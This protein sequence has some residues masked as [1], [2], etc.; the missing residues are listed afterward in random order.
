M[1]RTITALAFGLAASAAF[2]Q[3]KQAAK[4]AP[5]PFDP[6]PYIPA[7]TRSSYTQLVDSLISPLDK[8]RISTGIL[9]DRVL[10]TAGLVGFSQYSTSSASHLLQSYFE[11]YHAAYQLTGF[12]IKRAALSEAAEQEAT[13]ANTPGG[14]LPI[15]V[16]DYQ[17]NT[18]DTLAE[19]RGTIRNVNDLYYDGVGSPYLSNQV[20]LASPLADSV[21]QTVQVSLPTRFLLQ[22][23][24]RTLSS[25]LMQVGWNQI[26]LVPGSTTALTFPG[27]GLQSITFTLYFSDGS[28]T[29][30]RASVFVKSPM[31]ATRTNVVELPWPNTVKSLNWRGYDG[32]S[33]YGEGQVKS[34]LYHPLSQSDQNL[35]NPIM[36]MDGFDP[37]DRRSIEQIQED[38]KQLAP[39][40]Q[41][42]SK[43]RDLVILNFPRT[44][45]LTERLGRTRL[46]TIDGG[47]D[48]LER[49]ALVV[50]QL[51]NDMKSRMAD[52]TQK[53][54]I[55]APS[56]GGLITRYAL[57]LMEKNYADANNQATYLKP[58][59]KHN[60]DLYVSFD[61]PHQG[62]VIPLGD[63]AFIDYFKGVSLS[64]ERNLARLNSVAAR[65]MLLQHQLDPSGQQFH[66]P[67]MRAV[68]NN[69]LP[70][71]LGWPQQVRR[72][73][74]ANGSNTGQANTQAGQ[75]GATGIQLDVAR[76]AGATRRSFFYR[77]TTS[78]TQIAANMYFAPNA[79]N[80]STVFNGEAT[81]LVALVKK[82]NKRASLKISTPYNSYDVAPGGIYDAQ[83]Q[84]VTGTMKGKQMP[85][86]E[87]RFTTVRPNH[88]FI[89]TVSALA[90]Q[91]RTITGGYNG[92]AT[93]PDAY[94]NLSTRS[95]ICND[96]TPFDAYYAYNGNSKHVTLDAPA[97]AWLVRELFSQ[98]HPPTFL[99]SNASAICLNASTTIALTDCGQRGGNLTYT[100]T[101]TGPGVFT[102]TGT[103]SASGTGLTQ[104]IRSTGTDGTITL[105]VVATRAGATPS[106]AATIAVN[107]SAGSP[108]V[109]SYEFGPGQVRLCPNSTVTVKA[110]GQTTG[111]YYW[112]R[113]ST[114]GY[115][116]GTPG[117]YPVAF[118]E[119]TTTPYYT[120]QVVTA[121]IEVTVTAPS[122]CSG[123][124]LPVGRF[125]VQPDR[126]GRCNPYYRLSPVPSDGYIDVSSISE[127]EA[128]AT[129]AALQQLP[130]DENPH[131][132]QVEV[133]NDRGIVQKLG[134]TRN[135]KC[136]IDTS[137]LPSGLYHVRMRHGAQTE[138]RNI[139]ITH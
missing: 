88:C 80:M 132:Y 60:V 130:D 139:Q 138:T 97:Q 87:Y 83:Q 94:T 61:A 64:A 110:T 35:R 71:S 18:L 92:V 8:S 72:V 96:E 9:Y 51:L 62:A 91:Y 14:I 10:P 20:T 125:L 40:L 54:T 74:L 111:P 116:G 99:A 43:E 21:Y 102:S 13:A 103:T 117:N 93:L 34:I 28:S 12:P 136:R 66:I 63:Q 23:T 32:T 134:N 36:V 121:D 115:V 11:L 37:S 68:Q 45:R 59:W 75:A 105:S 85:G 118:R 58:Y 82:I 15:G 25:A 84:I 26:Y 55:I 127:T 57:A 101:L 137:T 29:T 67:F 27:T 6:Q 17:F 7:E 49:N 30:A 108:L 2:A 19:D 44:V 38:F 106:P 131:A 81:V 50:V 98:T 90:Y 16:L 24:G 126:S 133:F 95:L 112:T 135:G 109:I 46:D 78:G 5:Q 100:W 39:V 33:T 69:G 3:T 70:G 31:V 120:F 86:Y 73:A 47:A 114:R 56:M 53:V 1:K 124:N 122:A 129:T 22:N 113:S 77:S 52:P 65:Q 107:A 76:T 4:V 42:S 128:P 79:N 41:V 123:S 48:Y 89:P 119:T 104:E